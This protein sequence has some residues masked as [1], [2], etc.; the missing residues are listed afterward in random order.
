[1]R[2]TSS[3]GTCG[4]R[5]FRCRRTASRIELCPWPPRRHRRDPHAITVARWRAYSDK[6][7]ICTVRASERL[8]LNESRPA[9][10]L[11]AVPQDGLVDWNSSARRASN[12]GHI[13]FYTNNVMAKVGETDPGDQTDIARTNY[14]YLQRLSSFG[15]IFRRFPRAT[16]I[17]VKPYCS[18]Q[19]LFPK[20]IPQL[21][22][23]ML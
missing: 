3:P 16:A 7:R 14:H 11:T 22:D 12:L 21:R 20:Q 13:T 4:N 10:L 1:M 18:N 6:H 23:P 19:R 5:R 8:L 9:R 15:M 17:R 2:S